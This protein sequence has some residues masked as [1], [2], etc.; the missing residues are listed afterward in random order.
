MDHLGHPPPGS[1][2]KSPFADRTRKKM[3]HL[4]RSNASDSSSSVADDEDDGEE[5]EQSDQFFV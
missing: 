1:R 2:S 3:A 4:L 5:G